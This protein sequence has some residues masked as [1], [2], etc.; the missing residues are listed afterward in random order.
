MSLM[1]PEIPMEIPME[2]LAEIPGGDYA[3]DSAGV[4]QEGASRSVAGNG[5]GEIW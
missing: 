2:I 3:G 1:L 5:A 4:R